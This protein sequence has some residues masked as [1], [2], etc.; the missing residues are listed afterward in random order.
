MY[1][2]ITSNKFLK[3]SKLLKKRSISDLELFQD[4]ITI[5]ADKG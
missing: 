3:D 1:Q 5:L 4:F 2:I